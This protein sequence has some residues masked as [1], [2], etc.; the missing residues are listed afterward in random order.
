[1]RGLAG[2]ALQIAAN[3]EPAASLQAD[4]DGARGEQAAQRAASAPKRPADPSAGG[5]RSACPP[6]KTLILPHFE[7]SREPMRCHWR[8]TLGRHAPRAAALH[9][10]RRP[11]RAHSC[12]AAGG[13]GA[14]AT[15]A[16]GFEPP[17][18]VRALRSRLLA[19]MD[20]HVY[21]AEPVLEARP[22][23]A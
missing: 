17:A 11:P 16:P 21:K 3:S 7:R 18:R 13:A 12:G 5:V 14:G 15:G 10:P 8:I 22:R 9:A 1:V 2:R 20:A 6:A 23:C 4:R 19:F